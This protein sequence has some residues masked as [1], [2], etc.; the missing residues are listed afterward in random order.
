MLRWN[1]DEQALPMLLD[2]TK[3]LK[4]EKVIAKKRLQLVFHNS[5][6]KNIFKNIFRKNKKCDFQKKSDVFF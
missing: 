6:F 3:I 1:G 2:L 5:I 4:S